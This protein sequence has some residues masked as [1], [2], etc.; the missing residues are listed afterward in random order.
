MKNFDLK[1]GFHVSISGSIIN[2]II[3][4]EDL[5]CT[6]FQIFSRNPR[7]WNAKPLGGEDIQSFKKMIDE[8]YIDKRFIIVHMPYLPNLASPD[9][10][11]YYKS[12]STLYE[13]ITRCSLLG[14]SSVVLHLG[15][16]LGSGKQN[17]IN[18]II[19]A[20][21]FAIDTFK[22]NYKRHVALNIIFENSSGQKNS[23]GSKFEEIRILLDQLNDKKYAVCLDTCHAFAAGYDL[24]TAEEVSK[25]FKKFDDIIGIRNLKVLHLNDSKGQLN[26]NKDRHEHI[27]LGSIGKQGMKEI[28]KIKYLRQIPIIMETPVDDIR[29]N[30]DNMKAVVELF[31]N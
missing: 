14:I 31:N 18:Q 17:G 21:N 7:G 15:S 30:K 9:G 26:E 24:R 10:E 29:G 20:C 1:I 27:G 4:A 23:I 16:H 5:N 8:S 12:K 13:E 25:V 19:N 22:S 6:A 2:A 28:L 3:N 11:S